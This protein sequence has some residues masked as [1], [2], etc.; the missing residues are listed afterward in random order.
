M[1]T[2]IESNSKCYTSSKDIADAFNKHVSEI[3]EKLAQHINSNFNFNSFLNKKNS[4]SMAFFAPTTNEIYNT[5]QNLKNKKSAGVDGISTFFLKISANYISPYLMTLFEACFKFGIFP[6]V[7][8]V[9]KVIP[10]HKSGDKSKVNNY[11]PIS[12]LNSISKI[13]QKLL[14][15]RL[16]CFLN[17]YNI[18]YDRQY[19]FRKNRNTIL[20]ILD[21]VTRCY[22]NISG[23]KFNFITID[24]TKAFDTVN[25]RI[26]LKKLEFYGIRGICNDMFKSYLSNRQQAVHIKNEVSYTSIVKMGVPQGSVLGP[27]LFILYVNDIQNALDFST[28]HLFADDTCLL[29]SD[30]NPNNLHLNSKSELQNLKSWLDSNKLTLNAS[31]SNVISL[32]PSFRNT[33][34][35]S[36]PSIPFDDLAINITDLVKYLGIYIDRRLDFKH[37][38]SFIESKISRGVGIL[39]KL[40]NVLPSSALLCVYYSLIHSHLSYGIIIWGSTFKTYLSKLKV[41]QNKAMRAISGVGWSESATP[42]YQR[43][44]ILKVEDM[45]KLELAKFMHSLVSQSLPPSL[46]NYFADLKIISNRNTRSKTKGN[47]KTPLFKSSKTQNSIKYQ[48]T[49]VWNSI[50]LSFRKL[51]KRKFVDKYKHFLIQ[52]YK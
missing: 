14:A 31:K 30:F 17:K 45:Y 13:L 50:P 1:P 42:L 2:C 19:G 16:L 49:I 46:I 29:L 39:Y 4:N 52:K 33:S 43:Y 27:L 35:L 12:V 6:D 9:T 36:F 38:I 47:L 40:K 20:A 15:S 24:L 28:A 18:L 8:K 51:P 5:I 3:G 34:L 44:E 32:I 25:H 41:L 22:D 7:L 21:V 11:K 48:G 26:L 37:H 10:I 23:K